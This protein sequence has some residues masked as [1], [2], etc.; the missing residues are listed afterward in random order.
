MIYTHAAAAIIAAS[1]AG[2][3]G[4]SVQGWRLGE[5]IAALKTAQAEAV[6]TA[7]REARAQ[8]SA[9]FKGVQ[10]AQAAAQ[11]RAQV[12]RRDADRARGELDRM[13]DT[14]SATRG[15]VPGESTAACAVRADAGADVLA[16]CAAAYL[17]MAGIADRHANDART[18]I[19]AW[20]K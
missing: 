4:W 2:W 14:L 7:T 16:Q 12:A 17:S 11:T 20:P 19:E 9:R 3:A 8:E 13:R 6:N 15:G 5:Q 1:L 10:D 18:L